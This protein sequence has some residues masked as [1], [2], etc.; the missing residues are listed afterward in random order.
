MKKF[1]K[2]QIICKLVITK[3]LSTIT[4]LMRNF[5]AKFVRI[6]QICKDFAKNRVNELENVPRCRVVPK[7]S[8]LEVIALG[9]TV[10]WEDKICIYLIQP[11]SIIYMCIACQHIL[12]Q[13]H[14]SW[15][16]L[17]LGIIDLH[18]GLRRIAQELGVVELMPPILPSV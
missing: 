18:N 2:M 7:F 14:R 9:I 5:M 6:L 12:I 4:L 8:D 11:T 17:A 1:H 10:D 15:H 3:L 16:W 13:K